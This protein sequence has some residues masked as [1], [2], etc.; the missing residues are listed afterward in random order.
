MIEIK[1][2]SPILVL[3]YTFI[4]F[5]I[6]G[7]YWFVKTK[8]ELN[9]LGADIPSAWLMIIPLIRWYWIYKYAEGFAKFVKKD[10]NTTLWFLVLLFITPLAPPILQ[11]GL[12]K[13][14]E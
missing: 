14:V 12:N 5:G 10:N 3:I 8:N 6:Y 4:T 9:R 1:R 2:R 13:L 11:R 7:I